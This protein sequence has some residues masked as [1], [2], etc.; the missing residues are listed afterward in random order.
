MVDLSFS[1]KGKMFQME[2]YIITCKWVLFCL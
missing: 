2:F 1:G